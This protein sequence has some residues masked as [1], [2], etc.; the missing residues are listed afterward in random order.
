MAERTLRG[1][2]ASPGLAIGCARVLGGTTV[3]RETVPEERRPAELERA[4]AAL[5][6]AAAELEAI[7]ERV[8][9]DE[10]EIIRAGVL[11]AGDPVLVGDGERAGLE[12]LPAAAPLAAAPAPHPAPR[13]P[14]RVRTPAAPGR[15]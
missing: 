6:A 13:A 14:P 12:G 11:M 9:G 8:G 5:R 10:A 1:L 15:G 2:P 7:A 4:H 3:A